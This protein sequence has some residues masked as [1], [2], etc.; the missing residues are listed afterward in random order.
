MK[1]LMYEIA[2]DYINQYFNYS[3]PT[4]MTYDPRGSV[5]LECSFLYTH[6]ILGTVWFNYALLLDHTLKSPSKGFQCMIYQ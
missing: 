2:G 5:V 4:V 6:I 3:D 1:G